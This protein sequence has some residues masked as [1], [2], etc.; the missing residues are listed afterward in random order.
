M[1]L[2]AL[3]VDLRDG[4]NL[5]APEGEDPTATRAY[6]GVEADVVDEIDEIDLD[7]EEDDLEDEVQDQGA[8]PVDQN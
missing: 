5:G 4:K 3:G 6:A 8:A 2:R 1:K 7:D